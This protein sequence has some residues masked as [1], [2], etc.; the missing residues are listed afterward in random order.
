MQEAPQRFAIV[1][2]GL[3]GH[4]GIRCSIE[5]VIRP[6]VH[7]KL[8]WNSSTTQAIRIGLA[9]PEMVEIRSDAWC[10]VAV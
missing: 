6:R 3:L 10:G 8:D 9:S 2:L 1:A 5:A 4:A 7:V